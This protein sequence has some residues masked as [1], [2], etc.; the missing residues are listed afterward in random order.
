MEGRVKLHYMQKP[1]GRLAPK[2]PGILCVDAA[3]L[4]KAGALCGHVHALACQ[5]TGDKDV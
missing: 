2:L 3:P 5:Y 1:Q 4:W